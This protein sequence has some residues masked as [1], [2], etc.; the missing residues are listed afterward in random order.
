MKHILIAYAT[1]SGST[2][3]VAQTIGKE[4]SQ[5]GVQADVRPISAVRDI[6][7][8][9]AVIV[10]GPMIMGWHREAVQF[11]ERN[12]AALSQVPV[13][14]FLT[15]LS[16]TETRTGFDSIPVY[17]DPSLAKPPKNAD[18]LS[19]K[20]RYATVASY[21]QPVLE[22]APQVK[23][24]SAAFFAGKL[25]CS[26][27]DFLSRFFVQVIIGAQPGDYRNWDAIRVWAA[28]LRPTLVKA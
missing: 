2:A 10:G 20:E 13:A 21:L 9:D 19:F 6:S 17:K 8:Y 7:P 27:L 3:E 12:Q 4:L 14:C 18:R 28:S 26:K 24:V 16:L 5:D 11:L 15:A 22:K 1:K 23:P 25:D